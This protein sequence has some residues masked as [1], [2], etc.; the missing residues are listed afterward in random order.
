MAGSW[1]RRTTMEQSE[2][3]F[4][5]HEFRIAKQYRYR[6]NAQ[7]RMD[8]ST[9]PVPCS[10]VK[11]FFPRWKGS[12]RGWTT[13]LLGS[14]MVFGVARK[15]ETTVE[16]VPHPRLMVQSGPA[17][18]FAH[19]STSTDGTTTVL[20]LHH[21]RCRHYDTQTR[22]ATLVGNQRTSTRIFPL[23]GR[24]RVAFP[25]FPPLPSCLLVLLVGEEKG[26]E[27]KGAFCET[28]VRSTAN[29]PRTMAPSLGSI[30]K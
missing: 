9:V 10:T 27:E 18:L 30:S 5:R 26:L 23:W 29:F 20:H 17:V 8:R 7:Y 1:P 3:P 21:H 14:R 12:R 24:A 2:W 15:E 28:G 4:V 11:I 16:K 6:V 22:T 25:A 19:L 13:G